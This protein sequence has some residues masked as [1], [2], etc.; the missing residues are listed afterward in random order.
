MLTTSCGFQDSATLVGC[1]LA[2][3]CQNEDDYR[4]PPTLKGLGLALP[5][6]ELCPGESKIKYLTDI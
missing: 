4:F 5:E 2:T 3:P 6:Y 1:I